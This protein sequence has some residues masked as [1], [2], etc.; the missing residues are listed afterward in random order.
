MGS[1]SGK[2]SKY[3]QPEPLVT[4][5]APV[6]TYRKP[7]SAPYT[8]IVQSLPIPKPTPN[9]IPV[10]R[11]P[12][13][14]IVNPI[15][16]PKATPKLIP[17]EITPIKKTSEPKDSTFDLVGRI[18]GQ[19]TPHIQRSVSSSL[20]P[21]NAGN[22]AD[23]NLKLADPRIR[24][25]T[26]RRKDQNDQSYNLKPIDPDYTYKANDD[27]LI[28]FFNSK[29]S[30]VNQPSR[31]VGN[32]G[33]SSAEKNIIG[34]IVGN[35]T[36]QIKDS[37]SSIFN[38]A[39]DINHPD[40]AGIIKGS[41]TDDGTS[42]VVNQGGPLSRSYNTQ[43]A[44]SLNSFSYDNQGTDDALADAILT[45]LSPSIQ[46]NVKSILGKNTPYID[47]DSD[48]KLADDI[49]AKLSPSIQSD[50]KSILDS[51]AYTNQESDEKIA[52]SI[53]A[54]FAPSIETNVK[55][56]LGIGNGATS[57]NGQ[58]TRVDSGTR[59]KSNRPLQTYSY[60]ANSPLKDN[61]KIINSVINQ[62]SPQIKDSVSSIFNVAED[63]NH[64]DLAGIIKGSISDDGKSRVAN[65]G[66]P[67]SKSYNTKK[68]SPINTFSA[69]SGSSQP[70]QS[71]S[72]DTFSYDNQG[73]YKVSSD[74][75]L[76]YQPARP[77]KNVD[78]SSAEETIINK[79]IGNLQPQIKSSVASIFNVAEDIN[80]PDLGG[81][82]KGSISDD[83]KSRLT[84]QVTPLSSIYN[85]TKTSSSNTFTIN[86]RGVDDKLADEILAKLSPSIQT[87]VQSIL[88]TNNPI[89][90]QESDEQ[91][92]DDILAKLT[93]SIETNVKS[94]LGE[95]NV[96]A[97]GRNS[98]SPNNINSGTSSNPFQAYLIGIDNV[99]E[100]TNTYNG[101]DE[102]ITDE[103]LAKLTPS[104]TSSVQGLLGQSKNNGIK[105]GG[106]STIGND[107]IVSSI[108]K[109][110]SPQI[111]G[112]VDNIFNVAEDINHPHFGSDI[113][114]HKYQ[115]VSTNAFQPRSIDSGSSFISDEKLADE[116]LG[117]LAPFIKGSV[118]TYLSNKNG[119]KA[120]TSSEN[121]NFSE[122][123]ID[124]LLPTIKTMVGS[125]VG[126]STK[127]STF[128]NF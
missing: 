52:D 1:A 92:A 35:L 61:E 11:K 110:L 107:D 34:K 3:A 109:S 128:F 69:Y 76:G 123:L 86:N 113:K 98:K 118:G 42:R 47:N 82:I 70:T 31:R 68:T 46:A 104:V 51:N 87:N 7:T 53:L 88:S 27:G 55:S 72:S 111:K 45:K 48:D 37:V 89:F 95:N 62:L 103:I 41:V 63:I 125:K 10:A 66:K 122:G 50:V 44:S 17:V 115:K 77:A 54:K 18:I 25:I 96:V 49:L 56:L 114:N 8:P 78:S 60:G 85:P 119:N 99:A 90:D 108:I 127:K 106:S 97:S 112:S 26:Q 21:N 28:K 126:G 79:I 120:Y 73:P 9:I 30:P 65:S 59:K 29:Q 40:L 124:E 121:E 22:I 58:N 20:D 16:A 100:D 6:V 83:G 116:I 80:N 93:P 101:A 43:K 74:N 19:L 57:A 94:I 102:K 15:L 117:N 71:T 4:P 75:F 91:L 24:T 2:E 64:P 33:S 67:L 36:P 39:E 14:P 23:S 38:V 12:Y 105:S 13:K 5:A 32:I 81:I 84:N